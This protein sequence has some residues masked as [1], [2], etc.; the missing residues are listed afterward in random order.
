MNHAAVQANYDRLSRRYDLFA[1]NEKRCAEAACGCW[2]RSR[3][4]A[5]WRSA[6][7]RVTPSFG[8]RSVGLPRRGWT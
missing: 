7:G 6:A 8:W 2:T 3:V 4:S 5:P 1:G